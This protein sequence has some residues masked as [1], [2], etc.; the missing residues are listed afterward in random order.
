MWNDVSDEQIV[1]GVCQQDGEMSGDFIKTFAR[2]TYLEWFSES[3]EHDQERAEKL[4]FLELIVQVSL[5]NEYIRR[6]AL[7]ETSDGQAT[8]SFAVKQDDESLRLLTRTITRRFTWHPELKGNEAEEEVAAMARVKL[9]QRLM[10]LL[11]FRNEPHLLR[12]WLSAALDGTLNRILDNVRQS[13]KG[14]LET[15]KMRS[16]GHTEFVAS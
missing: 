12:E 8:R 4:L 5:V 1:T 11:K 10:P 6:L 14:Q 2:R 3:D 7:R 16:E 15:I 13:V 9:S